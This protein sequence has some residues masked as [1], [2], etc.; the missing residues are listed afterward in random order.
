[1]FCLLEC[2]K[3]GLASRLESV[4]TGT[5]L[6]EPRELAHRREYN[7]VRWFLEDH[8]AVKPQKRVIARMAYEA[9]CRWTNNQ[10]LTPVS[11][12]EFGRE[13]RRVFPDV[14]RR[15]VKVLSA[16]YYAYVGIIEKE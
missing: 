16:R 2:V 13:M 1:M 4:T 14:E 3:W 6:Q 12:A 10:K 7:P 5:L 15:R 8:Y 11:D 9:Y